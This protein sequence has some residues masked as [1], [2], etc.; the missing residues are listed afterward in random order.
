MK[1]STP[2]GGTTEVRTRVFGKST[3]LCTC[4]FHRT[5]STRDADRIA[6]NHAGSCRRGTPPAKWRSSSGSIGR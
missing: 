6:N 1:Y 3:V 2:V 4:G 5:V